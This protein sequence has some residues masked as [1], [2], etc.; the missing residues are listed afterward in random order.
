MGYKEKLERGERGS[1]VFSSSSDSI[2][3]G[4]CSDFWGDSL[5]LRFLDGSGTGVSAQG[6]EMNVYGNGRDMMLETLVHSL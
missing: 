2:S 5:D 4:A 1:K 3:G 6:H